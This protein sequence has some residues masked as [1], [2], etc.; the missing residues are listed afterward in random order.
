MLREGGEERIMLRRR[1]RRPDEK[2]QGRIC[3]VSCHVSSFGNFSRSQGLNCV[4]G[5]SWFLCIVV[6]SLHFLGSLFQVSGIAAFRTFLLSNVLLQIDMYIL[7]FSLLL[8]NYLFILFYLQ[9]P[10]CQMREIF[11]RAK[12]WSLRRNVKTVE[13]SACYFIYKPP[14]LQSMVDS[15][16]PSLFFQ[17]VS[18]CT[19]TCTH[20]APNYQSRENLASQKSHTLSI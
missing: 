8:L 1:G 11:S 12:E 9:S 3:V 7:K 13:I 6:S 4:R 18:F 10:T 15:D 16:F 14:L 2:A 5:V 19:V 20:W 17:G